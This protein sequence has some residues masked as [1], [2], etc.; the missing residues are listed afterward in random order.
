M[1]LEIIKMKIAF[2]SQVFTMQE[3]GGISRYI[4]SLAQQLIKSQGVEAKIFAPLNINAYLEP[5]PR[6]INFGVRVPR[7]PKTG[8]IVHVGS[9]LMAR[10]AIN[11]FNPKIVHETYYS[12][13]S[14]TPKNAHSVITVYDMIHEIFASEFPSSD[15]TSKLKRL[16]IK[17]ADH[18]ICISENTRQ[19]LLKLI[20]LPNDKV[21]VAYLGFDTLT[22]TTSKNESKN[23][24]YLLY[25]GQRRGYKNFEKFLRAYASSLWL[26]NNFQIICFGGGRF[27]IEEIKLCEELKLSNAK[28]NQINGGDGELANYYRGAAL[29]VYPSLYEGFGI[30]PLEAMSLSCPVACSNNSSIPEVV[31]G[32]AEF[33]DPRDVSSIR[34]AM[35]NVLISNSRR[36]QLV[37]SG[38]LHC[39]HFTWERCAEET[40][41]VYKSL[42]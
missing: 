11:R 29:F 3:Y 24:P 34:E 2:D 26:R 30:P 27:S 9:Q 15:Q 28:L 42:T 18:V 4:T 35:E 39:T 31:G 33:F 13:F 1:T 38:Q 10:L 8:N 19:D 16:A 32:A 6:S 21:S 7:I 25:V 14:S 5:L 23:E 12:R 41:A 22:P 36:T 40:L 20:D 37:E 17:R